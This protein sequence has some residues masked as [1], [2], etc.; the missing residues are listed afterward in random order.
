MLGVLDEALS[1]T[2]VLAAGLLRCF[3]QESLEFIRCQCRGAEIT[4]NILRNCTDGQRHRKLRTSTRLTILIALSPCRARPPVLLHHRFKLYTK[5]YKLIYLTLCYTVYTLQYT[6]HIL[7]LLLRP[8]RS[9]RPL[10][11]YTDLTRSSV[12]SLYFAVAVSTLHNRP[13]RSTFDAEF[14]CELI[15][16]RMRHTVE[17]YPHPLFFLNTEAIFIYF[18]LNIFTFRYKSH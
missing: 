1:K 17:L 7:Q 4:I 8:S 12:W 13:D 14:R 15:E 11:S 5:E 9:S 6:S 3:L 16:K 18:I 10:L 2:N